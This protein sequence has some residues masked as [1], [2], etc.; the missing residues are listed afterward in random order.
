[1]TIAR[2]IALQTL[3]VGDIFHA[4]SS[5]GA[6]LVCLVTAIDDGAIYARRI[7]TQDDVQFDRDTDFEVGKPHTRIDYVVPFPPDIHKIFLETDRKYQALMALVRQG[8]DL[9]RE[10]TK[11]TSDEKRASLS[12]D[13]HVAA[14]QL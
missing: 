8:V 10:Q 3:V 13:S 1:M 4:R 5:N 7:H 11:M 14:N 9:T 6:N 12:I 2:E